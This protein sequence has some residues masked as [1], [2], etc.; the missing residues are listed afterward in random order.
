M[1]PFPDR[2]TATGRW[3]PVLWSYT[4]DG[5]AETGLV[6]ALSVA[7]GGAPWPPH[8]RVRVDV[9]S[10]RSPA[11]LHRLARTARGPGVRLREENYRRAPDGSW[12][13]DDQRPPS[14]TEPALP[15][16]ALIHRNGRWTVL[17]GSGSTEQ[18]AKTGGI[19]LRSLVA[20]ALA[21]RGGLTVHASAAT[22]PDGRAVLFLGDGGTGKTTLALCLARS[23][24][25]FL[26]GDRTL[27]VPG[28]G[29]W[30]AVGAGLTA[31]LRWGTLEGMGLTERV[32]KSVLLRHGDG[33]CQVAEL[34]RAPA[35]V[36]L[37]PG[38]LVRVLDVPVADCA[39]L[40]GLV[41]LSPPSG[42]T[43][44]GSAVTGSA[45]TEAGPVARSLPLE[46]RDGVVRPHLLP[47]D[48]G[49][50]I[51]EVPGFP[52]RTAAGPSSPASRSDG[53]QEG[54]M[55][56]SSLVWNPERH[57]CQDALHRVLALPAEPGPVPE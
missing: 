49:M 57:G 50:L 42:S 51:G 10:T 1:P 44:T 26:S 8:D 21:D 11:A 4:S 35:K 34:P 45:A 37:T 14:A 9:R 28:P 12:V 18:R 55:H 53:S 6:E 41:V 20:A 15:R 43:T 19:L 31:R 38:E 56:I 39:P 33:D 29:G 32:R 24:G 48:A 40:G 3:G 54:P 13:S 5:D 27:L 22:G 17:H 46:T 25:R 16:H 7:P 36:H 30:W 52:S 23:G 2:R 47:S